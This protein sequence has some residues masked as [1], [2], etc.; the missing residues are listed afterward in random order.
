LHVKVGEEDLKP[1]DKELEKRRQEMFDRAQK[2]DAL[3]LAILR[4]HLLAEQCMIDYILATGIKRRW[5]RKKTFA[6]KMAKCKL[7]AKDD[8]DV[9]LWD[10]LDAANQ[11][12]NTIAHSLSVEKI[13]E[14]MKQLKDR[15]FAFLTEEQ[16]AGL[17]DQPDDYIAMTACSTCAGFI[18]TLKDRASAGKSPSAAVAS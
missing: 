4:T 12:R 11:L 14:K 9:E 2:M 5:L 17:A 3:T 7:L 18:A 15:Y 8:D 13:A 16:A 1:D 10:V 6:D